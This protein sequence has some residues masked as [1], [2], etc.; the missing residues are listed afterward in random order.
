MQIGAVDSWGENCFNE[1]IWPRRHVHPKATITNNFSTDTRREKL[2]RFGELHCT[3]TILYCTVL[4]CRFGE[5][6][7]TLD[8]EEGLMAFI[9]WLDSLGGNVILV[10]HKC[11]DFDAKVEDTVVI[12]QR[13]SL[14]S[15][16]NLY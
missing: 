12:E 7:Q 8:L 1:F 4:Y 3:S 16:Q 2:Y 10:A 13:L 15:S 6:L 5:Q 14:Y 9:D 11:L